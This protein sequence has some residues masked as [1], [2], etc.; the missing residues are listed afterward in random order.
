MFW[1]LNRLESWQV[2]D[3]VTSF[4]KTGS[5]TFNRIA[6]R[7]N[8]EEKFSALH[9]HLMHPAE[10][11]RAECNLITG[12]MIVWPLIQGRCN[13]RTRP[14]DTH[15]T[16]CHEDPVSSWIYTG[17][18]CP[19]AIYSV[20]L[21][22]QAWLTCLWVSL[23]PAPVSWWTLGDQ[24]HHNIGWCPGHCTGGKLVSSLVCAY[25]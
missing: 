12:V 9:L 23:D 25:T 17:C 5:G 16:P 11:S 6:H 20:L 3:C 19:S 21:S 4:H 2:R 15:V 7:I 10:Q 13:D 18:H 14:R 1:T 22:Q 24:G 8:S